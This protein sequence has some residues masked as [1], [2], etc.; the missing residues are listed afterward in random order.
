MA[1]IR[2][3]F[4]RLAQQYHP[5]VNPGDRAA[6]ERFQ[7]ISHAYH[8]LSDPV[9]RSQYDA[10]LRGPTVPYEE[11]SPRTAAEWYQQGLQCSR[12]GHHQD[13]IQAYTQAIRLNPQLLDA[14][15]QRGFSHYKLEKTVEAFADYAEALA[16]DSQQATSYYYR[17]L[18]RLKLG[19]N[20]GAIAD[21]SQAIAIDPN[22][23]QAYYHRGISYR[24]LDE[25]HQAK[26]DFM[27]AEQICLQQNNVLLANDARVAYQQLGKVGVAIAWGR[28]V[29]ALPSDLAMVLLRVVTRP[30]QSLTICSDRLPSQ[31]ASLL[32]FTLLIGFV[33]SLIHTV[34]SRWSNL[35][36]LAVIGDR[37]MVNTPSLIT[38]IGIGL[39]PFVVLMFGS[40]LTQLL[41]KQ[42]VEWQLSHFLAGIALLPLYGIIFALGRVSIPTF[43]I[44]SLI[45]GA[46]LL[47]LLYGSYRYSLQCN[48]TVAI[49][50]AICLA[51]I[52]T[53]PIAAL[54]L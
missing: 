39:M 29:S 38:L 22:H 1:E 20:Q 23:G 12:Q 19:Y 51:G 28:D 2:R 35:P 27:Q 47:L 14:H 37:A 49:A 21:F 6:L 44:I 40:V 3:A 46:Y 41:S 11:Q 13:A 34:N 4:R 7:Q 17:G 50:I 30:Q 54:V 16:L 43:G 31:R 45:C 53:L 18:T 25:P 10:T 33:L 5:D 48:H 24:E 15:N 8:V 9:T 52:V 36:M 42:Q 32:S 26:R